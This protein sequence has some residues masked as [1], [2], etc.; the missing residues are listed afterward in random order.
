MRID[1]S[2]NVLVGTTDNLPVANNDA[3]GIALR[4]DGNAQFS[5]SGAATARFNRGTS[6]GEIMS[7]HKD[8]TTVGSIGSAAGVVSYHVLDPR[9]GGVGIMGT[10]LN[11]IIPTDGTGTPADNAK[12]LGL[13]SQRWRD[14]YLGGTAAVTTSL[15]DGTAQFKTLNANTATPAEQFYVGN[16]LADV[17][18]GN[19]RGALKLF[20]GTTERMRIDSS[21]NVG[22]GTDSPSTKLMLEHNNDGAVGGTIR[23]KDKDS[24]Q[25]ANQLTGAIEFESEDATEPTSGVST[26]IK[27]FAASSTGGSYLTISTTDISTSTLDERMRIDSSGNVL[28]GKTSDAF[29]TAGVEIR[30][31]GRTRTTR[32]GGSVALFNRL[33]SNGNILEFYKDS[34]A[35]GTIGSISSGGS[36]LRIGDTSTGL[37]FRDDQVAIVPANSTSL[38]DNTTDLGNSSYRFKDLRLGGTAYVDELSVDNYKVNTTGTSTSATTQVAIKSISATSFRSARF[39]VQVTNTTDSTYHL[40]EVLVIHDGTTPSIT[41]YGT[42]FTGTAAEATFDAD[43]SS[44]NLRLLATPASADSMTFKV[45]AHAITS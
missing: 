27:A 31:E 11:N 17:D 45:V 29:G 19:K 14:L 44:N 20:T 34:T 42:I 37:C 33:N 13:H 4:A 38:V 40:T 26:A 9:S 32:D 6:D 18:L 25:S 1:S 24:Q 41:E 21:G 16:N 22:I 10:N 43:I 35:V 30:S 12:D 36:Q 15:E 28:V 3:S 5:R 8:G 39:T 7:F 23:I 2:G